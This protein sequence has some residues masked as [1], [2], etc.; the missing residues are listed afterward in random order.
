MITVALAIKPIALAWRSSN[1][2]EEFRDAYC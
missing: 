2:K 1:L